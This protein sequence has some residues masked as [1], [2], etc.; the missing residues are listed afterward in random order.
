M[1]RPLRSVMLG[2]PSYLSAY[3][4]GVAQAM[5]QLGHW[6]REV[7]VLDDLGRV[8]RQFDEMRPDVI[9]THTVP[10][11]PRESSAP[12]W[13][14]LD[15][16]AE[17]RKRGARVVLHDGDP[18][19]ATRH[20]HSIATSFDVAL[21][22]HRL[23]R[24][25]WKIPTVRWPYAAMAQRELGAPAEALRCGLLFAGIVRKD[26]GLY[27][28]R[29]ELLGILREKLGGRFTVRTG[30]VNDRM[31][32]ADVAASAQAVL[33]FGRPEVPGW[34]DTRIFQYSGAGGV[35][36]HDDAAEFLEPGV[37]FLQYAR[38][39]D[40]EATARNIVGIFAEAAAERGLPE[41]RQRAFEHVQAHHTWRHRVEQALALLEVA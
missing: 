19:H 17:W 29:T 15:L 24:A 33:G 14:F 41:M 6:H 16:L 1:K 5:G 13:A 11:V 39:A 9:W 23:P 34:A 20:P 31:Q 21:C 26:D 35:L 10:W 40:A 2:N 4:L 37:H 7:S 27:S 36:M 38:G 22:N 25:E 32:V 30:G 3:V 8:A 18:R 12:G 28:P